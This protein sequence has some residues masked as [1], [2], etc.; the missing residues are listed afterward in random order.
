MTIWNGEALD[1]PSEA[2]MPSLLA[3]AAREAP[4]EVAL[5]EAATGRS[6][7]FGGLL[8]SVRS[9]AGHLAGLGFGPGDR[10]GGLAGNSVGYVTATLAA[11]WLGGAM[12]GINPMSPP[13]EIRRQFAKVGAKVI[14]AD[15]PLAEAAEAAAPALGIGRVLMTGEGVGGGRG[16]QAPVA[17]ATDPALLPFSSGTTGLPKPVV[18]THANWVSQSA[19]TG[20][21]LGV[22]AGSRLLG[23]APLFHVV[24]PLVIGMGLVHRVPVVLVGRNDPVQLFDALETHRVTHVPCLPPVLKALAFHPAGEGRD[25]S[26][27]RYVGCGGTFLPPGLQEAAEARLGA[28]VGQVMGMTECMGGA[29]ADPAG[30]VVPGSAGFAFPNLSLR[31]ADPETGALLG[32]GATGELQVSGP[33]VTPGFLDLPGETAALFAADGW[34]RTGDLAEIDAD[35]RLWMRGRIKELIKVHAGQVA[36][37]EIEALLLQHPDVA[38]AAVIGRPNAHSGE[39]PVAYV[40]L[41]RE[42]DR[43]E[44]MEWVNDQLLPYK[45]LRAIERIA[46]IPRNPSGKIL[47]RDL[48]ALDAG[49]RAPAA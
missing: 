27:L 4:D 47:R 7:T 30:R 24:G 36:P 16:P 17:R 23:L 21:H 32:P 37:A 48:A 41:L 8:G 22:E 29:T 3:D 25:L 49:R 11:Q 43:F 5:I 19:G 42:V 18:L 20:H 45:R 12:S 9:M 15:P 26:A 2:T 28:A 10:L 13:E 46:A 31:I 34:L 40:A 38:D 6:V 14:L 1:W 33:V 44:V 39:I 35:G